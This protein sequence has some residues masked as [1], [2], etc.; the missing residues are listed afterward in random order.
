MGGYLLHV[1]AHHKTV[2]FP[3][4]LCETAWRNTKPKG[5]KGVKEVFQG[6]RD[7]GQAN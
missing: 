6:V 7:N 1:A 5:V 2:W 4:T 3:Q